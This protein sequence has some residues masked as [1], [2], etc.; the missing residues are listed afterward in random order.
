MKEKQLNS[1]PISI[2]RHKLHILSMLKN[3]VNFH[4]HFK[5]WCNAYEK[6][7]PKKYIFETGGKGN[8]R[9]QLNSNHIHA[10]G[11]Q[12]NSFVTMTNFSSSDYFRSSFSSFLAFFPKV[13]H[14]HPHPFYYLT[15]FSQQYFI[16]LF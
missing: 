9:M 10:I 16:L 4:M 3:F 8:N 1:K 15:L 11:E 12:Y 2:T 6:R 14:M 7:K 13:F 5:L